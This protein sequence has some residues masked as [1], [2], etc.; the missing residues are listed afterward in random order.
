MT[1]LPLA[2]ERRFSAREVADMLGCT[3][4]NV[5]RLIKAGKISA[6]KLDPTAPNSKHLIAESELRRYLASLETGA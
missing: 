5:N 1:P 2:P 6:R 4:A 3:R